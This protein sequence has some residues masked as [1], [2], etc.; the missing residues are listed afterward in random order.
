MLSICFGKFSVTELI[1]ENNEKEKT[2]VDNGWKTAE[3]KTI[4]KTQ[5]DTGWKTAENKTIEKTRVDTGWKTAENKSIE[6]TQVD[7]GWRQGQKTMNVPEPELLTDTIDMSDV[8]KVMERVEADS[9]A[10]FEEFREEVSG[11]KQLQSCSKK[12]YTVSP[13]MPE[14]GGEA[15]I[16][17]CKDE[18]NADIVAKVYYQKVKSQGS[19]IS[20]R[21][22]VLDYM[23]T[24]EG[25][26]YTVPVLEIGLVPLKGRLYYF[27]IMPYI[28]GGNIAHK[29]C[30][31]FEEIEKVTEDVNE[32][33]HSMH[34]FEII[35]RDIKTEN[36]YYYQGRY[37]LGDFG[38]AMVAVNGV[39]AGTKDHVGT[40]GYTAP[41]INMAFSNNP[42]FVYDTRSDYY[43]FGFALASLFEG[44]NVYTGMSYEQIS[45]S[46]RESKLPLLRMDDKREQ[47]ENLF[48]SL[49]RF[50]ATRRFQYE[51]VRKWLKNHDYTGN[52]EDGWPKKFKIN[53][54]VLKEEYSDEESLF[55]GIT[56]DSVH[57]NEGRD[58]LFNKYFENFFKSFMP[59]LARIAQLT[60]ETWQKKD[61]D[62]GLAVFLKSLYEFGAIVWKGYTFHSLEE[63]GNEMLAAQKPLVYA[64]FLQKNIIS[65]WLKNTKGIQVTKETAEL[66]D[67]IEQYSLTEPEIACYWFGNC[68]AKEKFVLICGQKVSSID[69]MMKVLLQSP[70]HF[71]L[72]EGLSKLQ[73]KRKGADLRGFLYSFGFKDLIVQMDE[74]QNK[75]NQFEK[76]S[77]ILS[78]LDHAAEKTE[79]ADAS[80][81]R[82]FFVKYGPVGAL[83]YTQSLVQ[84]KEQIYTGE[85]PDG[86]KLLKNIR[87]FSAGN[88]VTVDELFEA[89]RPL[90]KDIYTMQTM[91][92]DN[93]FLITTGTYYRKNILCHNL[94]GTFAFEFLDRKFPIGFCTVLEEG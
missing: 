25:Q 52:Y 85:N 75:G 4:E 60:E 91:M 73:N 76:V 29:G 12:R 54:G 32:A 71:Y 62:K 5:V 56:K 13:I 64:E 45:V 36:I 40:E 70:S 28:P 17:F 24:E 34:N 84:G 87:N 19:S 92:T 86:E 6:K 90:S 67:T 72:N 66:V 80:V 16:L 35:H 11:L 81:V 10:S 79:Q 68:F 37:V 94:L 3:N 26:K 23:A 31:S 50:D 41:E 89:Y 53:N 69:E 46:V 30:F 22:R 1:M 39:T 42:T 55:S 14:S 49:C 77:V 88:A 65:H 7:T 61:L 33:I 47:L 63:L 15:V 57:W 38:V 43:S 48:N 74:Q 93:P 82:N 51:D 8:V 44:R 20:A 18:K 21:K 9:C 27:E 83:R 78:M 2:V 59:D 58:L